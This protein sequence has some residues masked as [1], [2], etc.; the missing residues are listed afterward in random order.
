MAAA[1]VEATEPE[2]RDRA[3][4]T[5]RLVRGEQSGHCERRAAADPAAGSER[6]RS[7]WATN[8]SGI[9]DPRAAR[10]AAA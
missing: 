6:D 4:Q 3:R 9:A 1:S 7:R 8:G 5:P 2:N 10:P